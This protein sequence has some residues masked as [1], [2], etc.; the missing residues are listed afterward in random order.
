[1]IEFVH[2][3]DHISG[4]LL[5]DLLLKVLACHH[6]VSQRVKALD[7]EAMAANYRQLGQDRQDYTS[8]LEMIV[9]KQLGGVHERLYVLLNCLRVF[10]IGERLE[11]TLILNFLLLFNLISVDIELFEE[12][13]GAIGVTVG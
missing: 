10:C 8:Q 6:Q 9:D 13:E 3:V 2:F 1:M 7:S 5:H 4:Q 11:I 12:L